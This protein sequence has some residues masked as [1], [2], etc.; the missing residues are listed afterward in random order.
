MVFTNLMDSSSIILLSPIQTPTVLIG[1]AILLSRSGKLPTARDLHSTVHTL[2]LNAH[3]RMLSVHTLDE[4]IYIPGWFWHSTGVLQSVPPD[5]KVFLDS[6]L[7]PEKQIGEMIINTKRLSKSWCYSLGYPRRLAAFL[8][9]HGSLVDPHTGKEVN[10]FELEEY[11]MVLT[12]SGFTLHKGASE[13]SICIYKG[14]VGVYDNKWYEALVF[15]TDA[16]IDG[17]MEQPTREKL[18]V[19]PDV[20]WAKSIYNMITMNHKVI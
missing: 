15:L 16:T 9:E 11:T 1:W 4:Q 17:S 3:H 7:P 18:D 8:N 12:A 19:K 10:G 20:P 5:L 14:L 2:K 6:M 13:G